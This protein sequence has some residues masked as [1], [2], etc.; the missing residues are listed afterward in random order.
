MK[1]HFHLTLFHC[2][3]H[4]DIETSL[5]DEVHRLEFRDLSLDVTPLQSNDFMVA[6]FP[7][8]GMTLPSI[9]LANCRIAHP[10]L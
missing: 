1:G 8:V 5:F 2:L 4:E 6:Y 7:D 3:R 10:G 9:M